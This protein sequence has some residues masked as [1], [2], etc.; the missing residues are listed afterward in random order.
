[1]QG[2]LSG[3]L[4]RNLDDSAALDELHDLLCESMSLN[5]GAKT[6]GKFKN[7]WVA[8]LDGYV[9][10]LPKIRVINS[11][12]YDRAIADL[13]GARE[14][15][16]EAEG[17]VSELEAK[18]DRLVIAKT[19]EEAIEIALPEN[20]RARFDLLEKRAR[21]ALAELPLVVRDAIW[22]NLR[23]EEMPW[24][25][26]FDGRDGVEEAHQAGLLKSGP[27]DDGVV[28][29]LEYDEVRAAVEEVEKIDGFLN[30]ETRSEAF[31]EWFRNEYKVPLHLR[32]KRVW[33]TIL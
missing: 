25:G 17:K 29:N 33:D 27:N 1:M 7:Q 9:E 18:V 3:L 15:L 16:R 28:P 10:Q 8:R 2:V 12:D 22:F 14:A 30:E 21:E 31:A 13:V 6:W 11:N 26:V 5:P 23:N 19:T 20:E 32:H 4:V 24:P